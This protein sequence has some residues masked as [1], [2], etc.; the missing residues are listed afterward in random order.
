MI[1]QEFNKLLSINLEFGR[2]QGGLGSVSLVFGFTTVSGEGCYRD[3]ERAEGGVVRV[4]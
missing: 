2:L 4:H 1:G 3:E